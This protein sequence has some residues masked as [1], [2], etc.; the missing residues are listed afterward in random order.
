MQYIFKFSGTIQM[1]K[2]T[3]EEPVRVEETFEDNF[4]HSKTDKSHVEIEETAWKKQAK[5]GHENEVYPKDAP[6]RA[7]AS[8]LSICS[9]LILLVLVPTNVLFN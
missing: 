2:K 8:R 6:Y 3:Q 9:V 7:S 4:V 5:K 1:T